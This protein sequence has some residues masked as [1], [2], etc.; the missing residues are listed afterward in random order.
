MPTLSEMIRQASSMRTSPK[1]LKELVEEV[2][3]ILVDER[4]ESSNRINGGVIL[5][6]N[7]RFIVL[8]DTHGDLD[9][10][11]KIL[12]KVDVTR[13]L[14]DNK[15]YLVFLGDYVDRGHNQIETVSLILLLKKHYP[16]RV[17]TLRGNHEPPRELPPYPHDFPYVLQVHFGGEAWELY[18]RFGEWFN[19]LPYTAIAKES[20]LFLHGG[21]PVGTLKDGIDYR[22][23]LSLDTYPPMLSVLEEILWNDPVEYIDYAEPSPR[24]AGKVFGPKVTLK[25]L[26][27]TGTKAIVRGHEPVPEGYKFNHNGRVVTLFSRLGSPYFNTKAA[28]MFID[29]RVPGWENDLS[30]WIRQIS[31]DEEPEVS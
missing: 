7:T 27:I 31:V 8:G 11:V 17:I 21:P 30:E 1:M 23:Y 18:N 12:S 24:G 2:I 6:G 15:G 4:R 3:G 19:E 5:P 14:D 13:F 9:T 25:A 22:E 10:L 28:Y 16:E 29:T 26:E 20:I